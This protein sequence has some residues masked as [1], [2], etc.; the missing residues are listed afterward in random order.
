[1][2]VVIAAVAVAVAVT[3]VAVAVTVV[4]VAATV[5]AEDWQREALR[6][7]RMADLLRMA[8]LSAPLLPITGT[9]TEAGTPA[10]LTGQNQPQANTLRWDTCPPRWPARTIII[11]RPTSTAASRAGATR[12][13]LA[14]VPQTR[15]IVGTIATVPASQLQTTGQIAARRA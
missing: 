2:V 6:P 4:V 7:V 10:H 14:S 11:I 3:V 12:F 9:L 5:V 1:V 8:A 13:P 15:S